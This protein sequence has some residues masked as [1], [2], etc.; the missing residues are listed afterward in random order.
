M[1]IHKPLPIDK[2]RKILKKCSRR[3]S[4]CD[5]IVRYSQFEPESS[6]RK[7]EMIGCP[8]IYS[9]SLSEAKLSLFPRLFVKGFRT[10]LREHHDV[11]IY[12]TVFKICCFEQNLLKIFNLISVSSKICRHTQYSETFMGILKL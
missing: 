6:D 10:T 9:E 8:A 2:N 5:S 7:S 1:H 3:D 11:L 4:R 12:L